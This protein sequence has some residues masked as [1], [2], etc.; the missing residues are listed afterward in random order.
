VITLAGGCICTISKKQKIVTKSSTE[1]EIV[2]ISD[3]CNYILWLRQLLENIGFDMPPAVIHEDNHQ[4]PP[5]CVGEH[6]HEET[7]SYQFPIFIRDRVLGECTL[8]HTPGDD[9]IADLMTKPIE[10]PRLKKLC[11]GMMCIDNDER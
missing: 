4:P 8:V 7:S 1:S 3:S 5:S 6:S 10:G 2:A 11:H 9:M